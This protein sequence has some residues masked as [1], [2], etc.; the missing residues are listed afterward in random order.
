VNPQKPASIEDHEA[1]DRVL[2]QC[3][4]EVARLGVGKLLSFTLEMQAHVAYAF[5]SK[6]PPAS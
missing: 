1:A 2:E 5:G 6:H 4:T 3:E